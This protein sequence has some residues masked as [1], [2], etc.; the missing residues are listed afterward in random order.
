MFGV[1]LPPP[2]VGSTNTY[3]WSTSIRPCSGIRVAGMPSFCTNRCVFSETLE[4][5]TKLEDG[6]AISSLSYCAVYR[7]GAQYGSGEPF[8][9]VWAEARPVVVARYHDGRLQVAERHYVVARLGVQ[10]DVDFFVGDALLVQRLVGGVALHA[11]RLGVNGDAHWRYNPSVWLSNT[12][13]LPLKYCYSANR[14]AA[15]FPFRRFA[16]AG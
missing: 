12:D 2:Y 10:G 9:P 4:K 16:S 8:D 6:T 5:Y 11:G 1:T 15:E 7:S 3:G 13:W 14:R